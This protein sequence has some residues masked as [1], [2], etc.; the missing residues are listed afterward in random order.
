MKE[1]RRE[2]REKV[3]GEKTIIFFFFIYF[4]FSMPPRISALSFS[5][6]GLLLSYHL[7]AFGGLSPKHVKGIQRFAGSS[8]GAVA[9]LACGVWGCDPDSHS[10]RR[11]VEEFALRGKSL[12]GLDLMLPPDAHILAS[13]RVFLGLTVA[14]TGAP[15]LASSFSSRE[16][17]LSAVLASCRIPRSFHPFDMLGLGG[18]VSYP[19]EEG[20]VLPDGVSYVDGGIS[21]AAPLPPRHDDAGLCGHRSSTSS[22]SSSG[23]SS[24]TSGSTSSRSSQRNDGVTVTVSPLSGPPSSSRPH[25][26]S[27]PASG[28]VTLLR[29]T[30]AGLPVYPSL[31]NARA[32][33]ASVMGTEQQLQDCHRAGIEDG[34]R[35]AKTF[36][37]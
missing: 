35:F 31:E 14:K 11:F 3:L 19:E 16:H 30:I 34:R 25:R 2:N 9:A 17:L 6:S 20:I 5:G 8:G 7:G 15:H 28:V 26:I 10:M 1:G 23:T 37:D 4:F 21:Q 33:V 18:A 36:L 12:D 32:L 22:D 29:W 24:G 13:G 27:P